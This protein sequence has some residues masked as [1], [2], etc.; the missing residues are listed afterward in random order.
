MS[1]ADDCHYTRTF[2]P[3]VADLTFRR[4]LRMGTWWDTKV[5]IYYNMDQKKLAFTS[6]CVT[7]F[8]L[9]LEP[10]SLG[11]WSFSREPF[12]L[13]T[14]MSIACQLL[15]RFMPYR[16]WSRCPPSSSA[17]AC[18]EMETLHAQIDR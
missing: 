13:S 12:G 6:N 14:G 17:S 9:L 18:V 1:T 10:T 8:L 5:T 15:M 2:A 7:A 11:R 3:V 16:L 4:E